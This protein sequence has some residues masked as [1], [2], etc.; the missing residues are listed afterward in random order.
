MFENHSQQLIRCKCS[1][2]IAKDTAASEREI[3]ALKE[4]NAQ[5][6]RQLLV[7]QQ[8][9]HQQSEHIAEVSVLQV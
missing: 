4:E 5:L 3:S 9:H 6:Q 1:Q 7:S 2:G 8:Q